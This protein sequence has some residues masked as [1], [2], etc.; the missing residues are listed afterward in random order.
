MSKTCYP[1]TVLALT[2]AM[3]A[4]ELA[5]NAA[6]REGASEGELSFLHTA[7]SRITTRREMLREDSIPAN[8]GRVLAQLSPKMK[9]MLDAARRGIV[10]GIGADHL[11]AS[12]PM[13]WKPEADYLVAVGLMERR[14][15]GGYV[16]AR[17]GS[18]DATSNRTPHDF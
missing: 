6:A 3:D 11:E 2:V 10:V 4:L 18:A 1:E 16:P 12:N 14:A 17:G 7:H 8:D 15:D 13:T 5:I 9:R